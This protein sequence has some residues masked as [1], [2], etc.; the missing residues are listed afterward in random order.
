MDVTIRDNII[1]R[2]ASAFAISGS[3][4]Y[5]GTVS[6]VTIQNNFLD[7][8]GTAWSSGKPVPPLFVLGG[9]KKLV[10]ENNTAS[11]SVT[12]AN[13][14]MALDN[15][16]SPGLRV[17]GNIFPLFQ[18]GVKGKGRGSGMPTIT[19]AGRDVVFTNNVLY[20][21]TVSASNYPPGNYLPAVAS[22]V[23]WIDSAGG[24]YNLAPASPYFKAGLSGGNIG[25]SYS[26]ILAATANV[27]AGR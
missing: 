21:S 2:A 25:C 20:G 5:K 11:S 14:L 18:Y 3:N 10:I 27:I 12:G 4:A 19:A 24:N 23:G 6:N 1:R 17:V 26:A 7:Q 16:A 22:M 9:S 13:N 8:I 15:P